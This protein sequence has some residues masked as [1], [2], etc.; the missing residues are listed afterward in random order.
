MGSSYQLLL[1]GQAADPDLYTA[2]TSLEVE[3]SMDLPGAVQLTLPVGTSESGDLTYVSDSRFQ[4][5]VNL[6]VVI[7]PAAGSAA[8]SPAP[9]LGGAA[10]ALGVGGSG[11]PARSASST[12]TYSPTRSIWKPATPTQPC[13]SGDRT[14]HG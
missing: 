14:P 13:R 12:G 3:E 7:T 10:A 5:L 1:N 9:S 4:P 2:I 6:A 8:G 11:S